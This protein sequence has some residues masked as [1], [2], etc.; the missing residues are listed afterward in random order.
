[1]IRYLI[2]A[3]ALTAGCEQLKSPQRIKELEG[4]VNE[5]STQV[6]TLKADSNA[7]KPAAGEPANDH[8]AANPGPGEHAAEGSGAQ[9]SAVTP[10]A[11]E[12]A[13]AR[14]GSGHAATVEPPVDAGVADAGLSKQQDALVRLQSLVARTAGPGKASDPARPGSP[15]HWDYD[16]RTGP[17]MWGALDPAWHTCQDGV[18]QSPID[19]E[20]RA[21]SASPI[22]FRY[23][24]TAAAILDNG[25][26]L[27]V[28]LA[29]GN[30]IEIDGKSYALLQLHFHMPS[31]HTIAG[32]H[33]PLEAH[34]VHQDATGKLAVV[35]VLFDAGGDSKALAGLWAKWPRKVGAEEK[36]AK[37]F[38]PSAVLP[39]TRTV[40]RY[41]GSL[42]T[43]PCTEGVVWNVMRRTLADARQHLDAFGRHYPHNA[44][45]L[46]ANNDRKIE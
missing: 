16:G 33:Y 17:A 28:N 23:K 32:E 29:A 10:A 30:S 22:T 40:F 46:Q 26:T 11:T 7:A 14:E 2:A 15:P 20:P 41:P 42:T 9:G 1:M 24:P 39:E 45:T 6:A 36:L 12:P 13:A 18:A 25:H 27:Q 21:G 34:L 31:E 37:L 43:P 5:L 44:R 8:G 35:G 19:I 4:R 38:D 3:A